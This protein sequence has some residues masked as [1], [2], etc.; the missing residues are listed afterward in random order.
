MENLIIRNERPDDY[1]VVENL[2]REAFWNVYRPGCTEHYVLRCLRDDAAFIP[3]DDGRKLPMMTV[4]PISIA[5]EHQ[6]KGYGK[7]LLDH[8]LEKAKEMGAGCICMEGNIKFYGKCGFKVAS[9]MGIHYYAEPREEE[10]PYFLIK[11]LQKGFLDG[12]T[13]VYHTPKGYFVDE[14]EAELFD[15]K[16]PPKEK[17]KLPGQLF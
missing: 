10:V 2:T 11:E 1:N 12:V 4:G 7:K 6:R 3:A 13:G 17:L 5:P 9:S 16:F 15:A 14:N 8:A